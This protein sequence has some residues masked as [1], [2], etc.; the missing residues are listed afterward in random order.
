MSSEQLETRVA[1]QSLLELLLLLESKFCAWCRRGNFCVSRSSVKRAHSAAG[2]LSGNNC[3]ALFCKVAY[4]FYCYCSYFNSK[5]RRHCRA[6][7]S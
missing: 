4:Y 5:L 1:P 2:S 3:A 7:V 6:G